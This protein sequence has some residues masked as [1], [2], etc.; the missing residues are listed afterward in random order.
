MCKTTVAAAFIVA[1]C[2]TS[3]DA[4]SLREWTSTS[5][6]KSKAVFVRANKETVTLLK[7]ITVP[8]SRLSKADREFIAKQ[9]ALPTWDE[10]SEW[11]QSTSFSVKEAGAKLLIARDK[12]SY[13]PEQVVAAIDIANSVTPWIDG[14]KSM[15]TKNHAARELMMA[16]Q[17]LPADMVK[18]LS[19]TNEQLDV[20][21]LRELNHK[22]DSLSPERMVELARTQGTWK[23]AGE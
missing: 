22:L 18:V 3:V 14:T 23:H 12:L 10:V 6:K 15:A 8:L 11:R 17:S 4:Q 19:M 9:A 13:T 2:F 5:G 16:C 7:Q 1:A 21:G 20:Q